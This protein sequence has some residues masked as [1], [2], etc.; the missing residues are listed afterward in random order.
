MH[1][2][3]PHCKSIYHVGA[4]KV[5]S[6][7]GFVR[8]GN[9]KYK[10]NIH[11]QAKFDQIDQFDRN[12]EISSASE[13][14]QASDI[15]SI[16]SESEL[17]N[18]DRVEPSLDNSDQDPFNIQFDSAVD[19]ALFDPALEQTIEIDS[20]DD[21]V[22]MDVDFGSDAEESSTINEML[23][24][25]DE[26]ASSIPFDAALNEEF[27][28][29]AEQ[30]IK[31][32]G[33]EKESKSSGFLSGVWSFIKFIFWLVTIAWLAYLLIDQ[34]KEKLY[35][36]YKNDPIVQDIRGY[37]CDYLPCDDE[38]ADIDLLEMAFS[39]MDEVKQPNRQ[40]HI[41]IIL[42]NKAKRA[43]N[44]P[45]I[46]ISFISLNGSVVGQR[47]I[48]PTEYFTSQDNLIS[49]DAVNSAELT[50]TIAPNK[51]GKILIKFDNPP[52][53]AVGFEAKVVR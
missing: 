53:N 46:L 24:S 29:E 21:D 32:E 5:E 12:I 18:D 26:D 11:D 25:D 37:V 16:S 20:E 52:E 22:Y 38:H 17:L 30:Q 15:H 41:S 6:L 9:C 14:V 4:D 51:L 40:F 19:D 8:C 33:E 7:G 45:N 42:L 13:L 43:Q 10:F 3:C 36:L 50:R 35:P 49:P 1:T 23:M 39:R 2:Q 48:P 27:R 44:Y 28:A 47:V 31:D 34:I